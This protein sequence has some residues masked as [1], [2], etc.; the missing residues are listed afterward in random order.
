MEKISRLDRRGKVTAKRREF[1][2]FEFLD[3]C[4]GSGGIYY[5]GKE[6]TVVPEEKDNARR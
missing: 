5:S 3:S 4:G 6:D 1:V 2:A